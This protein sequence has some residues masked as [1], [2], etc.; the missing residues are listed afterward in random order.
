MDLSGYVDGYFSYNSNRPAS[1][2]NDFYNFN[3]QGQFNL[4]AAKLTLESRS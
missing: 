4:E 3:D 2:T 1:N